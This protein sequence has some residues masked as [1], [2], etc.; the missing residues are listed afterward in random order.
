MG[1]DGSITI[2]RDKDVREVWPDCDELFACLP[3]HYKDTLDGTEYHHCFIGDC[4][5][6]NWLN[7]YY[8]RANVS[9]ERLLKFIDWLEDNEAACWEVW[10]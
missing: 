6:I 1:A 9:E 8:M 5:S 3:T 7:D 4:P 2:W 10:T